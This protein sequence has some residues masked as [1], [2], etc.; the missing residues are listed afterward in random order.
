MN[1]HIYFMSALVL[2]F[3][4]NG[5]KD[6]NDDVMKNLGNMIAKPVLISYNRM[7]L[8]TRD[9]IQTNNTYIQTKFRL[10]VYMDS[11]H[12]TECTLKG[13]HLWEDFIKL[14]NKYKDRLKV[15]FLLQPDKR[16]SVKEIVDALNHYEVKYPIYI[17]S[18][19]VFSSMNPHI[20]TEEMYHVFLVDE[21]DSVVLVGNPQF[22]PDIENRLLGILEQKLN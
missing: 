15:E 12:C 9:S 18:S 13:M 2:L 8:W 19:Y 14:E 16:N 10:V 20:P 11:V 21:N 22:N 1:R 4:L 7:K 6:T 3:L 5:C 17:D